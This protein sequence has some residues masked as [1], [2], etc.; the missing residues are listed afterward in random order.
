MLSHDAAPELIGHAVGGVCPF[1]VREG[2]A[3]YL[4]TSLKSFPKVYPAAGTA[5][6]A[7]E[8]TPE[9]LESAIP[10]CVWIDVSA[11]R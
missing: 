5:N 4:D 6:S 2:V 9:E 10:G 11:L 8:F 3:I 1:G 7:V